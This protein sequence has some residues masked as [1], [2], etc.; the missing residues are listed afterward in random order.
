ML[1]IA[2]TVTKSVNARL[3][4]FSLYC[5]KAYNTENMTRVLPR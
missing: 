2:R 3:A 4:T 5:I 1:A